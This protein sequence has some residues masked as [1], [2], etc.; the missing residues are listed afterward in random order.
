[1]AVKTEVKLQPA[2]CDGP[3]CSVV[4][5]AQQS[6]RCRRAYSRA[7]WRVAND[8]LKSTSGRLKKA[9]LIK[10]KH[11]NKTVSKKASD[12]AKAKFAQWH[13]S[14]AQAKQQLGI[15]GFCMLNGKTPTGQALYKLVTILVVVNCVS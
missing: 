4:D 10:S 11:H 13:H 14:V 2:S 3:G 5:T 1:M 8:L 15:Q 7:K 6:T 9:Q 12:A